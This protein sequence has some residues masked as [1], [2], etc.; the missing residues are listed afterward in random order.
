MRDE[1]EGFGSFILIYIYKEA[2]SLLFNDYND[3]AMT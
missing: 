3:P 2:N 1:R